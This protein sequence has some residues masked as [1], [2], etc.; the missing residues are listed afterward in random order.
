LGENVLRVDDAEG[1][2]LPVEVLSRG[3]R[4][5]LFLSLRLALAASYARRG[6]P[7]PLV[8][9]DVLVNFDAD[10]AKAAAKV[11]RDF[12]AEGHQILVFTCHEHILKLFTSLKV[13]VSRLP[14]NSE[15]GAACV[16]FEQAAAKKPRRR[17]RAATSSPDQHVRRQKD[18][19]G[20]EITAVDERGQPQAS[21][22]SE[23]DLFEPPDDDLPWDEEEGLDSSQIDPD[24]EYAE[25]Y[26]DDEEDGSEED[27]EEDELE[28]ADV[29]CEWEADADG[30]EEI[31]EDEE[32]TD[33]YEEED[34][35]EAA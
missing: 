3:T 23:N 12:A 31:E 14:D 21:E 18:D 35:A 25:G 34:P 5:Q 16:A 15:V 17:K 26:D 28:D 20:D 33:D 1:H 32:E 7:L 8:L 29:Q 27:Y 30:E 4:E 24:N 11:L 10:R 13:A 9:D 19:P 22:V 2:S 6:A